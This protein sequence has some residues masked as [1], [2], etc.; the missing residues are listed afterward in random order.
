MIEKLKK[1]LEDGEQRIAQT[2]S[3]TE[4]QDV[5]ASLLGKQSVFTEGM[6]EMPKIRSFRRAL[7][8]MGADLFEDFAYIKRA[9]IL[10]QSDYKRSEKLE[11][12]EGLKEYYREIVE[13]KQ[14]VTV[15]ELAV[16]GKDLIAMGMEPGPGIGEVLNKLLDRVL[17]EPEL[18]E[19]EKL[20]EIAKEY[21][22]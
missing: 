19:R 3:E 14:C 4:L 11:K 21:V 20:M 22:H 12:L 15:K 5:K 13:K 8:K 2:M 10:A 1:I 7:N 9:D 16:T 17:D 6:K 18:N